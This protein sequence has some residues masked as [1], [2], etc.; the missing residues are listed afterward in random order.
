MGHW[1]VTKGVLSV[2]S[3]SHPWSAFADL[4]I[5]A[6]APLTEWLRELPDAE[7]EQLVRSNLIRH[8]DSPL[9]RTTWANLWRTIALAGDLADRAADA[10][11]HWLDQVEEHLA[12]NPDDAEAKDFRRRCQHALER[13]DKNVDQLGSDD[14]VDS[15]TGRLIRAIYEHELA[16]READL[17]ARD[18]DVELWGRARNST[19]RL[20]RA[21]KRR[22]R[23]RPPPRR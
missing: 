15:V 5:P 7:F 21:L 19:E 14:L 3:P 13:I 18:I 8:D 12:T 16:T 23:G 2:S 6:P 1:P 4:V 10:L 11:E 22:D 17:P 20:L 9:G